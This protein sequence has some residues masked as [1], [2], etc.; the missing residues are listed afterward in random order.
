MRLGVDY[1]DC[2]VL[3]SLYPDVE[4]TVTAWRAMETLVPSKVAHLS[5]SNTDLQTL[6]R[7]WEAATI[8]PISIQNRFAGAT[9]RTPD[10][11]EPPGIP[12]PQV[13]YD[14]DIRAFCRD[15]DIWYAPWGLLWGNPGI[16]DDDPDWPMH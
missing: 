13:P 10:S 14:R 8:K 6:R 16:M 3:H 7:L 12:Y 4:D 1:I 15:H 2:L 5:L 9:A 11:A